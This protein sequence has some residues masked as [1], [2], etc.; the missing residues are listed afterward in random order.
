MTAQEFLASKRLS[1]TP[2]DFQENETWEYIAK[3][4]EEYHRKQ[5]IRIWNIR[6][7]VP[8]DASD[9]EIER[10]Y[11]KVQVTLSGYMYDPTDN[12]K[13]AITSF[14]NDKMK[15]VVIEPMDL[16]KDGCLFYVTPH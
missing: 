3:M 7:P 6:V 13:K 10:F 11:Q 1:F 4:L 15:G 12:D 2:T 8:E 14:F 9:I 5:T 16:P